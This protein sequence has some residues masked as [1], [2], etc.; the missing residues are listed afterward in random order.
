MLKNH[1]FEGENGLTIAIT[2]QGV[3]YLSRICRMVGEW[4]FTGKEVSK[5]RQIEGGEYYLYH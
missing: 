4:F 5:Q 3:L 2:Y 1:I